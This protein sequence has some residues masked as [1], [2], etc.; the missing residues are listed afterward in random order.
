MKNKILYIAA[1]LLLGVS[2]IS[3]RD[4]SILSQGGEGKMTLH[5]SVMSEIK[6]VSR[7]LTEEQQNQL[8]SSALIWISNS[9][10]DLLYRFNGLTNFPADG[11]TLSSGSYIAEA[12]VG[13]SIPA[14]WEGIRYHG[15][16]SFEITPG[17]TTPVEL[18]CPVRN[19]LVSL[20]LSE[21][22]SN[23][24][25]DI[26]FTV[27]LN[28]GITDGSHG[29]VFKG[30]KL[31]QKGYYMI[32]TRT[33]GFLWT[34]SGTD[35]TG[36]TFTSSGEYKDPAVT[37]A[38]YLARATEYIFNVK[39]DQTD[40]DI[41]IGG[42]YLDIEV[43]PEPV[44][45]TKQEVLIAL[46]PE[47]VGLD[48]LDLSSPGLSE[49]GNVGRKSIHIIGASPLTSVIVKSDMFT[50]IEGA[51]DYDLLKMSSEH[52]TALNAAGVTFTTYDNRPEAD[53]ADGSTA[54]TN[55]RLNLEETF[56]NALPAG[57]YELSITATDLDGKTSSATLAINVS[58][59]PGQLNE[60]NPD[61]DLDYTTATISATVSKPG[62]RMGFEVKQLSSGRSYE[63]WTF[64]E[65]TLNGSLLTATLTDL[66]N[67]TSYAFRL[68]IDEYTSSQQNTFTTTAYPQL[69]NAGF[70]NWQTDSKANLI[71]G[72]GESMFWDSG[73]HGSA[74][75]NKNV[76]TPDSDIKHSGNYSAK[77][78][79][80]FVGIGSFIGRFAAGNLFAGQYLVTDGT[81]GVLGWGR[82]WTVQPKSLKGYV[83]YSPATINYVSSDAPEYV[84]GDMDKGII[85]IALLTENASESYTSSGQTYTY[86][87]IVKTNSSERRLFEKDGKDRPNV[88][89]YGEKV[90][91]SATAGDGMVEFEIPIE[92]VS[93]GKVAYIMIVASA[94]KG[95][96]YFTGGDG[97][98]MWLDDLELV[99]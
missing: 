87:I 43:S 20:N 1:S 62:T 81:D 75:M 85:Y 34:I 26:S 39:Y 41:E 28:D 27:S 36:K 86:P 18:V 97:S 17:V 44:E 93:G 67:G 68:V 60:V 52:T 56:T 30:D 82:P 94:S 46:A 58:D 24:L 53:K 69:P 23:V 29:L 9:D 66:V 50:S 8:C 84:K 49:P 16:Q 11:L 71:Y 54:A 83:K 63:D 77:L 88:V 70:E 47:I 72:S 42:A 38:P 12:W 2:A 21:S 90:F 59:V 35:N 31:S 33:E 5:T 3:C 92:E 13:D 45:G 15:S 91:D 57:E 61:T 10:R 19:T 99:Y 74:T 89:A 78:S 98:T 25:S 76:T 51:S 73:N 48:G 37:E 80:Q 55:L 14:S 32:N 4:E 40:G 95:G 79:S 96:D 64:V 65:G 22:L 6:V 7:A